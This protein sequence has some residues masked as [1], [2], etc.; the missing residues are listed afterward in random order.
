MGTEDLKWRYGPTGQS[1]LV[2]D[3]PGEET[4]LLMNEDGT[5]LVH[6]D[7]ASDEPVA[8]LDIMVRKPAQKPTLGSVAGKYWFAEVLIEASPTQNGSVFMGLARG[9]GQ[10][11]LNAD[12]SLSAS[13]RGAES[14]FGPGDGAFTKEL[15]NFSSGGSFAIQDGGTY[16]GSVVVTLQSDDPGPPDVLRM[17]PDSGNRILIGTDRDATS[18]E[19]LFLVAIRQTTG[20]RASDIG[21]AMRSIGLEY[22]PRQYDIPTMGG[23]VSVP[24]FAPFSTSENLTFDNGRIVTPGIFMHGWGRNDLVT[25][26][27]EV[28][29][30]QEGTEG[31]IPFTVQPTGRWF[32]GKSSKSEEVTGAFSP[33]GS[34]GFY[35]FSADGPDDLFGLGFFFKQPPE[36]P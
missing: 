13:G 17:F 18:D 33:D 31:P 27:V 16:D 12:G 7:G 28:T 6:Y 3:G 34:F 14:V 24:D 20:M 23:T 35:S 1:V 29:N 5:I 25:G 22:E 21:G 4:E 8:A 32:I 15:E 10:L 9:F 26:G 19:V 36:T 11:T 2:E 30:V